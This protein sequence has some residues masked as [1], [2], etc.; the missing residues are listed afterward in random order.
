[1][2][3]K[4]PLS[5]GSSGQTAGDQGVRKVED[6]ETVQLI[7]PQSYHMQKSPAELWRLTDTW[8]HLSKL[9]SD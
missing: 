3:K 7:G 9:R 1:M 5:G 2:W 8:A 4:F 6:V